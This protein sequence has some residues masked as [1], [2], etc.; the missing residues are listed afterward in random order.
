M[1]TLKS[2]HCKRVFGW[3]ALS[4]GLS[5]TGACDG[6]V[7]TNQDIPPMD[8]SDTTDV[9]AEILI[10][11]T[12]D[13]T[14]TT[15]TAIPDTDVA[16]PDADTTVP[17]TTDTTDTT[18]STDT[19]DS[20]EPDADTT[21]TDTSDPCSPNPCTAP[22]DGCDGTTLERYEAIGACT[23]DTAVRCAYTLTSTTD[24]AQTNQ[25][26]S[27]EALACVTPDLPLELVSTA[28]GSN[29][30]GV[31]VAAPIVLTFNQ[32]MAAATLTS[33]TTAGPCTGNVQVSF[34]NFTSCIA[35]ATDTAVL[36]NN[37]SVAT[38]TPAPALAWGLTYQLRI[39]ADV[40]A[41]NAQT[42]G[43]TVTQS[44]ATGPATACDGP[45]VVISQVYGGGG[46]APG[47]FTH[48][49]VELKNRTASPITL[50]GWSLNYASASG[51]SWSGRVALSGVIPAGGYWL[52]QLGSSGS[53]NTALPT[54][55]QSAGVN[56]SS[57]NGK[58]ALALGTEV[59]PDGCPPAARTIDLLGYGTATCFEGTA[60]SATTLPTAVHRQVLGCSDADT[61]NTDTLVAAPK[62][63]NSATTPA[64]CACTDDVVANGNAL[65]DVDF[66]NL[67]FPASMTVDH[68]AT[69]PEIFGRIFID[70]LTNQTTG[71]A[72][73]V[74]AQVGF[75][76]DATNPLDQ[77]DWVFFDATFNV[78]FGNDDEYRGVFATPVTVPPALTTF[79][80]TYRVSLDDGASWSYCDRDGA[81]TNPGLG[82]D[83]TKLGRLLVGDD[84]CD[85]NPC[86]TATGAPFCEGDV[87]QTFTA[88]G[89]CAIVGTAASCTYPTAAGTDCATTDGRCSNGACVDC[90]GTPDCDGP[91]EVC[92]NFTCVVQ[93]P[94]APNP[95]T[96]VRPATCDGNVLVTPA[97][98]GGCTFIGEVTTCDYDTTAT[99]TTCPAGCTD[100]ACN[101]PTLT[102]LSTTPADA[103]TGVLV[104]ANIA[105]TF[106][107]PLTPTT[108]TA[109]ATTGACTGSVQVS[110]DGFTTCIG[111][112][113][114]LSAGDT[115]VTL[116][117]VDDL[118][119]GL[120]YGLRVT[121]ELRSTA[122]AAL[123]TAFN[124][125]FSTPAP[126]AC[127]GAV[128]VMSQVY[129][130]GGNASAQ[131]TNDFVVL[132]NTTAGPITLDG[133]SLQY[134]SSTGTTWGS[135]NNLVA[136][137]G[138]IA[139]GGRFLVQ[140]GAG[141]TPSGALPTPD[142]VGLINLSATTGKVALVTG[143]A[144]LPQV[145]CPDTARLIDFLAF[146]NAS[147]CGTFGRLGAL[148]N[149]TAAHRDVAGC[150]DT[151]TN[152]TDFTIAAPAPL[153][154]A[155]AP[156]F[157]ACADDVIRN[158]TS[159]ALEA[160]F[161]NLQFPAQIGVPAGAQTPL[162]YG[163]IYEAGKTNV[164]TG[165]A[166]GIRAQLGFGRPTTSPLTQRNWV[167]ADASFNVEAG[168]DDEYQASFRAPFAPNLTTY[169]YTYRFS[170]DD[171]ASW[172][173]C[174]TNGAGSDGNLEFTADRLGL[175]TIGGTPCLPNPCTTPDANFC[176]GTSVR[177]Y[178]SPGTCEVVNDQASCTYASTP[179][180]NC[181]TSGQQCF[182]GACVDCLGTPD[183]E[184]PFEACTS[185][186]CVAQCT[187]DTLAN[188]S[189]LTP[190]ALTGDYTATDLVACPSTSD[191][192]SFSVTTNTT[193]S[194]Q[195]T[196]DARSALTLTLR[197]SQSSIV[198]TSNSATTTETLN[199]VSTSA[200]SYT[201]VVTD[202]GGQGATYDIVVG[203]SGDPCVPNPCTEV[204]TPTCDG[205]VR[206]VPASPGVCSGSAVCDYDTTATRTT[207][208]FG[209]QSGVCNPPPA[210]ELSSSLPID[211]ATNVDV[212][213]VFALTF[214]RAL[215]LTSVTSVATTG[216]CVGS[217]QLSSD[218]FT[219]CVGL[220]ISF[221]NGDTTM[222]LTAEP[223]LAYGVTYTLRLSSDLRPA[224]GTALTGPID[225]TYTTDP[226]TLCGGPAAVISQVFAGGGATGAAFSHDF[227]EVRNRTTEA[228]VLD[229]WS[230]QVVTGTGA[231]RAVNVTPLHGTLVPG[232][233]HLVQLA[234]AGANGVAL[235]TADQVGA[236]AI[237]TSGTVVLA[238]TVSSVAA[239]CPANATTL[240]A[241]GFGDTDCSP[242]APLAALTTGAI[243]R[244]MVGCS[245]TGIW[246]S[247]LFVGVPTP[248]NTSTA[249]AFC[250]CTDEPA[251][252]DTTDPTLTPLEV[253]FCNIQFPP[254]VAVDA[255]ADSTLIYGQVFH[256]GLTT[257]GGQATGIRS[258]LGFGAFGS[259]PL[260]QQS[261]VFFDATFNNEASNND[262]YKLSLRA[263]GVTGLKSYAYAYR[264]SLDGG[265]SWTYC[266]TNGAGKN[267]INL[268]FEPAQLGR[269]VV[270][271][272]CSRDAECL[273]GGTCNTATFTCTYPPLPVGY[274]KLQAPAAATVDAGSD[275]FT[276]GRVYIQGLTDRTGNAND[277]DAAGR[278]LAQAGYGPTGSLPTEASWLWSVSGIPTPGYVGPGGDDT[279]ND[280]YRATL[281]PATAGTFDLAM[282]FS[283]DGGTTW[284][285]CDQD[286][287]TP[288]N[289]LP[290]TPA[291]AGVLTVNPGGP[292]TI[293]LYTQNFDALPTS[294]TNVTNIA[295]SVF[296]TALPGWAI[297][298]TVVTRGI[299]NGG[300]TGGTVYSFGT[301][302]ATDRALGGLASGSTGTQHWGFCYT[303]SQASPI[304]DLTL[305]YVGE[306]WRVAQLNAN[307]LDVS[308]SLEAAVASDLATT[309]D[310]D[311]G[312]T[313]LNAL[314]FVS[315]TLSST[316]AAL[317]GNAAA[318]R[319]AKTYSWTGLNL[320]VGSSLCVRW[321]D[322]DN[323]GG[324]HGLAIDDLILRGT[325]AP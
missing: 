195:L 244:D 163:R 253:D 86:T 216:A 277:P 32:P 243:H 49:F 46:D 270:N 165:A 65:L 96:D 183:C 221:A 317:D 111:L 177:T 13:T 25:V 80:Y 9:D 246:S 260:T 154:S 299:S 112:T 123:T 127:G 76:L 63:H 237:S 68:G 55:D 292:A 95:C 206:V 228:L 31:D 37:S 196:H 184:V 164:G 223:A 232:G 11:D 142:Q 30:T 146:G 276:Y 325:L 199:Y 272:D 290:Y 301:S 220:D 166:E 201:L 185:N 188:T 56:I 101:V 157:C 182:N 23:F 310:D 53:N 60:A 213:E 132:R 42:L 278:V 110:Y 104:T 83:P 72:P 319:T 207:C 75:G 66:C 222:L 85:P 148:S 70:G 94:C 267:D 214:D 138:V 235:P 109:Q 4:V 24:C 45:R 256:N 22:P 321:R 173:Y 300:G 238:T 136:L 287:A 283:G 291:Q 190:F 288:D 307:Q 92:D 202:G 225:L 3:L 187:D 114:A 130:G 69:V 198:A 128:V 88:P 38:L 26:C 239:T 233:F 140:L 125:T 73:G 8:T 28:P 117:P 74:L 57:T 322:I 29:A 155:A 102:V 113:T 297:T 35:F 116:T 186:A 162:V 7:V 316:A 231:S 208:D 145:A 118:T 279:N 209:C 324:D 40:A 257:A 179:L 14:D 226:A 296:L 1:N 281:V 131:F 176:E 311:A 189:P 41:G 171:G 314:D 318:N 27:D 284:L 255:G 61:N 93:N 34:D 229:G 168:N 147:E 224:V 240:D 150:V 234:S 306:Q 197:D 119:Y 200:G 248:R 308:Y 298:S 170:L 51:A 302:S 258:Q 289:G 181:A 265:A 268:V 263:P 124:A 156:S 77:R 191:F 252:N 89:T 294:A 52:V 242:D 82:F 175:L 273:A 271:G 254:S 67:Q 174:D 295:A 275:L 320:A 17:E 217:V 108:V 161:C 269:M 286:G 106:S 261:W 36:S 5:V 193:I 247:D 151:D 15:D 20:T 6:T 139:P 160:D 219:T 313:R 105:L 126:T 315:P 203:L 44:F 172:T 266:D 309:V 50:N 12:S 133:W 115:V 149:T 99:R 90:L 2:L 312:W 64:F 10:P 178:V 241:I 54:P 59:L 210:L 262:E 293:E 259:N 192:F 91:N 103:A 282:R 141:S 215:D 227:V 143:T 245:L 71:Q 97:S 62:P 19:A 107:N 305:D 33:Q 205:N 58:L 87:I 16:D 304:I 274:C 167:F 78:E 159:A 48:D 135:G 236:A 251:V 120:T 18:D 180:T 79:A 122:D 134:T 84:P 47:V 211:G 39:A 303:N 137:R 21:E 285:Y 218:G 129:G 169:N 144:A 323:S 230:L 204:R 158:E 249:A 250:A 98:P 43:A 100:G 280:E 194:V 152:A 121:T 81:G 153:N 212:D 264:V